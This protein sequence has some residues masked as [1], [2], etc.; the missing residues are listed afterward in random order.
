M[1]QIYTIN[2]VSPNTMSK[3]FLKNNCTLQLN[4][5]LKLFYWLP[6]QKTNKEICSYCRIIKI[7]MFEIHTYVAR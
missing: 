3:M 2:D 5:L 4:H 1:K 7:Y 6:I